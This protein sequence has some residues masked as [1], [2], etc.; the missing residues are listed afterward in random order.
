MTSAHG[1][2]KKMKPDKVRTGVGP[3][4]MAYFCTKS[5]QLGPT[6]LIMKSFFDKIVLLSFTSPMQYF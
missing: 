2:G 4:W 6:K 3:I 5:T 1:G